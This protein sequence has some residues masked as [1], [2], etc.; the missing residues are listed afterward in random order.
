ML[1]RDAAPED[2]AAA[3]IVMRRSIK[4]LCAAD[5]HNDPTAIAAWTANKTEA[6]F[7]MWVARK[8]ASLLVVVETDQI[9]AVDSVTDDGTVDLNYVSPDA[10]FRGASRALLRAHEARSGA[11]TAGVASWKRRRR[12]AGFT[13]RTA[14]AQFRGRT[15][16]AVRLQAS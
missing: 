2:A 16:R 12:P 15:Q 7:Q 8:N 10:R 13:R 14:I 11:R 9:L 4:E 6:N 5:H 3:C 1:V